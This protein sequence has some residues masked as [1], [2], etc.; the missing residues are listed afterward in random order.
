MYKRPLRLHIETIHRNIRYQ[1]SMCNFQATRKANLGVHEKAAHDGQ[2]GSRKRKVNSF[3]E[4]VSNSLLEDP[5]NE[6]QSVTH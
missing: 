6:E 2:K 3:A 4:E 1:C 5:T